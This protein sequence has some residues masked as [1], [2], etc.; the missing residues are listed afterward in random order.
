[1]GC[2][3]APIE[4]T[5]DHRFVVDHGELVMQLV[6]AG[7]ARAA[8]SLV[9]AVVSKDPLRDAQDSPDCISQNPSQK[10][11]GSRIETP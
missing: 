1:M 10:G 2:R 3:G 4:R 5:R 7:E 9:V 8:H 11:T 6:T